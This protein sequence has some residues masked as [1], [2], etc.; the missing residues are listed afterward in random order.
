MNKKFIALALTL[1]LGLTACRLHKDEPQPKPDTNQP[2]PEQPKEPEKPAQPE[3]KIV[4]EG[5]VLKS[6]PETKVAED[7]VVTL[8]AT[9]TEIGEGAFAGNTKIKTLVAPGL[10]KIGARAFAGATAFHLLDLSSYKPEGQS[11]YPETALDAFLGTPAD[12]VVK[13]PANPS[14]I[15]WFEYI[16]LHTFGAIDGLQ[17]NLPEGAVVKD[18]ELKSL[19]KN[20]KAQANGLLVLPETVTKIGESFLNQDQNKGRTTIKLIYGTGVKEI[21]DGAFSES[22]IYFAHFP[23]LEKIGSGTF[24]SLSGLKALSFPVLKEIGDLNFLAA[25][26]TNKHSLF[27]VSMPK[28]EKVGKGTFA[29]TLSTVKTLILGAKPT[30]DK[31]R[32]TFDMAMDLDKEWVPF[33]YDDQIS[34][35]GKR[36]AEATL[37]VSSAD[38]ASYGVK[39]GEKWEGFT[40]KELK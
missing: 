31:T 34:F 28:L 15:A 4:I 5:G 36:V 8:E 35:A 3:A 21:A 29:A 30:I 12:K 2:Q 19:P 17:P 40:V 20:Y 27:F 6:Y 32:F 16:A 13:I 9:V 7:G 33:F 22:Y 1:S 23:K 24:G 10:K 25:G 26:S 18:G 11:V 38:L 37:Y 39:A 14:Y